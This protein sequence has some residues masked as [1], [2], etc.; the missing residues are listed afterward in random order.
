MENSLG[1]LLPLYSV[2]PFV[3][4]LLSIALGPV[5]FP[6]F[7]D[8][9]FGKVS[10]AWA[11]ILA[12]P[13]I[14]FFGKQGV[15]EL[16]FILIADYVPFIIL[17][18]AL[19]TVGGGI[20]IRTTLKGTTAVNV[21]FLTIG[22]FLASLMGTTGAAMLLIRPFLRVN[23]HRKYK[24]FLVIFFIF[25]IANVGGSLTPLGDPPLFLGF[26]HGVPF[27]W[28]LKLFFP[29]VVVLAA[30]MILYV[31][32]DRYHLA[33]ER[34]EG[35]L[36]SESQVSANSEN[37]SDTLPSGKKIEILGFQNFILLAVVIGVIIFSG[38][39]KMSEVNILG[40]Q[41]GLQDVIRNLVLVLIMFISMKITP[42]SLRE[43]NDFSWGPILEVTY[44]FFGIFI[45]MVPALSILKAGE[46]GSL[47]F[48]TAAVNSPAQYFWITGALSGVL[49]NAPTYL[50]FFSTALGQFYPGMAEAQAVALLIEN[51]S[52]YLLAISAGS[53]F[54]G[55]MTYIG[56]AP[57][58]MVRS[59]A[60]EAG[61][62]MPSFFGYMVWS[63]AIL[64]PIYAL[65]T[66]LFF[67]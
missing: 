53:V 21:G 8:N 5:L 58:F 51:Q 55:A 61:V 18:G 62:K 47:A 9:H 29:M 7:W 27:F 13:L 2:I 59:M 65:V 12:I 41:M 19:F 14:I 66:L 20:L 35:G 45:T 1:T 34:K 46:A 37:N 22:S 17:L 26:L 64:L 32:F 44:L 39:V 23:K 33:K 16:L 52:T 28:T 48:I 50:T 3:G 54:F 30:L 43:E 63:F 24:A 36:S 57:N 11:C 25:T 60:E 31:I 10:F 56:N 49:D 15:D 42:K 4:M 67:I 6:K 38:S 40:V